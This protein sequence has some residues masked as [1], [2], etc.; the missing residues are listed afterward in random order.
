[1]T[2]L[3]LVCVAVV[4][5]L[6]T[7]AAHAEEKKKREEVSAADAEK[8][9]NFFGKFVDS[10]VQNKDNCPSMAKAV[11]AVIDANQDAVK[12]AADAKAANKTLPK[13]IEE[14]MMARVKEL[15]PAMQKCGGD[16]DVKAAIAKLDKKDEK[17]AEK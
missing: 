9:L 4:V 1:M 13:A 7:G 2:L 16:K 8:M 17:K 14:K 11:T 10:I 12:L 5:M 6:G 15:M 3:R